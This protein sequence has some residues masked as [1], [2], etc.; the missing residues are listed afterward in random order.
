MQACII[1]VPKE[2]VF[3]Q[4]QASPTASVVLNIRSGMSLSLKQIT[5][6]K[7]LIA[8]SIA[9]LTAENVSIVNQDGEPLGDNDSNLFQ[10]EL[11]KSQIRYKKEFEHNIEQKIINVLATRYR[12]YR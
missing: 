3:A 11:V 6:I 2:T 4:K 7:N 8:A 1:A 5:G 9:N 12:R 10:G